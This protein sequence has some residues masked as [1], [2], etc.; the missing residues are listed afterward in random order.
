MSYPDVAKYS[1]KWVILN[2]SETFTISSRKCT[3]GFFIM[4]VERQFGQIIRFSD[5]ERS[6][7][8]VQLAQ[9]CN[10]MANVLCYTNGASIAVFLSVNIFKAVYNLE[11]YVLGQRVN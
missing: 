6:R 8:R 1:K 4:I 10:N 3:I 9:R 11:H 5:D 7:T 2:K